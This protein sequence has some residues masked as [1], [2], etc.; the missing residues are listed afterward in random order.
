MRR[1]TSISIF[2]DRVA[3]NSVL[4]SLVHGQLKQLGILKQLFEEAHGLGVILTIG[5]ALVYGKAKV[6]GLMH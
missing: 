4:N 3:E 5:Y 6:N 2:F 1:S